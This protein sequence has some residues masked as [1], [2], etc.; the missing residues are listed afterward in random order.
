MN[1]GRLSRMVTFYLS[2][3]SV[4]QENMMKGSNFFDAVGF[5]AYRLAMKIHSLQDKRI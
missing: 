1:D 4:N 5:I 2:Y 3:G